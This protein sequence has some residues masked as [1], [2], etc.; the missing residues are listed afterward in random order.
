MTSLDELDDL[1]IHDSRFEIGMKL[2]NSCQ[3]YKSHDVFEE[4]WHE[5]GGHERQLIQGILQVAVAQV[6]LENGNLNGAT[7][8]YGEA[9]GRLK[10]FHLTNFGLD[11]EGLS[12]CVS[13]RLEFLQIGKDLADCSLPVLRFL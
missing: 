4:I 5:T 6:H 10:K 11:I 3:W 2:F 1:F 9:L 12:N 13:R 8:L 7:I